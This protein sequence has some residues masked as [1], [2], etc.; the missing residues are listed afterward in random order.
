MLVATEYYITTAARLFLHLLHF[1]AVCFHVNRETAKRTGLYNPRDD[2]VGL[3]PPVPHRA[4]A[5]TTT[6]TRPAGRPVRMTDAAGAR[7]LVRLP[8]LC[9]F[10]PSHVYNIG[11]VVLPRIFIRS[12]FECAAP[13]SRR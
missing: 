8:G 6:T 1:A 5:A 4:A 11:V 9:L 2:V 12:Q 7:P 13:T 3:L 10:S